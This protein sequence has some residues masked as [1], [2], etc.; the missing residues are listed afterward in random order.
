MRLGTGLQAIGSSSLLRL[1]LCLLILGSAASAQTVAEQATVAAAVSTPA[2][3]MAAPAS[4]AAAVAPA[5]QATP[6]QNLQSEVPLRVMVG[7]SVLINTSDRL[8]RVS[9]TD[10]TVADALVVTPTQILVH[11]RAPGEISLII[12]DEME[13]SRSFD[14]RVDVDITAASEEIKSIF[15]K[16][17]IT[18]TASRSAIVLSGHVN[19]K[20]DA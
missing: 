2:G 9:V 19:T 4:A 1:L 20:E 12:W 11:G 17:S 8:R 3:A 14:L 7:K 16:D 15:P 13:H 5:G 10:P 18:L 6:Q